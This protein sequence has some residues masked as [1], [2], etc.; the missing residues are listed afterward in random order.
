MSLAV[1]I[2]KVGMDTDGDFVRAHLSVLVRLLFP[3]R[4]DI[5]LGNFSSIVSGFHYFMLT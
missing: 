4:P 1:N 5:L 2:Q 3:R